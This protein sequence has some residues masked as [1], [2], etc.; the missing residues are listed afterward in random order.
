MAFNVSA[1]AWESDVNINNNTS[2]AHLRVTITTTEPSF[3]NY[4][5]YGTMV[6]DGQSYSHGPYTL[7][8]TTT[9]T[10]ESTK[11]IT[12]NSDGSKSINS[13]EKNYTL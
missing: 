1:S 8:H 11:T 13:N 4:N 2:V 3:S 9:R 7:P 10:F 6:I 12:H 5:H